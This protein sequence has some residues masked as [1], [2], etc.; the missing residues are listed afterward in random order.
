MDSQLSAGGKDDRRDNKDDEARDGSQHQDPRAESESDDK[1]E[2]PD[3]DGSGDGRRDDKNEAP[4]LDGS[5]DGRRDDK[6]EAPHLSDNDRPP[7]SAKSDDQKR[8]PQHSDRGRDDETNAVEHERTK[9]QHGRGSRGH[10]RRRKQHIGSR[11]RSR[12]MQNIAHGDRFHRHSHQERN[13]NKDRFTTE[14]SIRRVAEDVMQQKEA[15]WR[16]QT[17]I[18]RQNLEHQNQVLAR[19]QEQLRKVEEKDVAITADHKLQEEVILAIQAELDT[20]HRLQQIQEASFHEMA[21]SQQDEELLEE[22]NRLSRFVDQRKTDKISELLA[23]LNLTNFGDVELIS[24]NIFNG[25][26]IFVFPRTAAVRNREGN[27]SDSVGKRHQDFMASKKWLDEICY[28]K[29]GTRSKCT[30]SYTYSD[31]CIHYFCPSLCL[32][33]EDDC[34][35]F[36]PGPPSFQ[37]P[38]AKCEEIEEFHS[39]LWVW[40]LLPFIGLFVLGIF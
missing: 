19:I 2:A 37:C 23:A 33:N 13:R 10:G 40:I 30:L 9:Q 20:V 4:Y 12:K 8:K 31:P 6:N 5:G 25:S 28:N 21:M 32:W 11:R 24:S 16:N 27:I 17:Q 22:Q 7:D 38:Y 14:A 39:L 1:N 35:D 29:N 15:N 34:H 18:F 3:L 26:N 36:D